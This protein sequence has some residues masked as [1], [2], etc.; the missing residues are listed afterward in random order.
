[1][2]GAIIGDLAGSIYEYEQLKEI[3]SIHITE[4]IVKES[5]YSDDTILTVAMID[6]ILN[7]RNY[8]RYL[9]EYI[10]KYSDY[11][12]DFNPY[13]KNT[14]SPGLMNWSKTSLLGFSKGNGA[15]MRISPIGYLFDKEEEVVKNARLATIPSHNSLEAIETATIVALMIFYFRQGLSKEE[16]YKKLNIKLEC[17][18]FRKFN[19]TCYE[20]L[21]NCLYV[22]YHSTSFQS[23]IA[24]MLLLGGDTDTNA[25]IIG[26]LAE[27]IYGID[28]NLKNEAE[29]KLPK[30]FVKVL[31]KGSIMIK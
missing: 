5:F 7:D 17:K 2:Y 20:T 16:V 31:R 24:N 22:L 14:F 19:T 11:K 29:K 26:S 27:A 13:F 30:E 6:A 1:M 9:R 28:E 3:K 18:P 8:D 10:K 25:A 21:S 12:P 4:L 15:L 23:S